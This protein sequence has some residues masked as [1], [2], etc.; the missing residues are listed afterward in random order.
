MSNS[1][2]RVVVI[3]LD[4]AD[5]RLLSP[6]IEQGS[7]PTLAQLVA[8]GRAGPL[9]STVRPES[10]VAWSS[11]ATGAN[12]G[13]HGIF[14]FVRAEPSS[15]R[16]VLANGDDIRARRFWEILGDYG[17]RVGL[18][19]VPF[20][21]PPRPVNGFLV[22]GM[23]TPGTHV[24]FTHPAALQSQILER[25]PDYCF[26]PS[27][28]LADRAALVTK[29]ARCT[30][31]QRDV[32]LW[33]LTEDDCDCL[34]VVFTGPDRLQHYVWPPAGSLQLDLLTDHYRMLDDAIAQILEKL[35][36]DT[37]LLV[38]SDHGFNSVGR[39]FFVNRW[40]YRQGL[41]ALRDT[42]QSRSLLAG[43]LS[44]LKQV[45]LLR[46]LKQSLLGPGW[47]P[48]Q[49]KRQQFSQS[50]DWAL[51]RAYFSPDGGLRIQPARSTTGGDEEPGE[52]YAQ[53][54]RQLQQGLT[55]LRDE[56][57]GLPVISSV[58]RRE[59][60]YSGP[61]VHEAPDLIV[62]PYR[63]HPE[64]EGNFILDGTLRDISGPLFEDAVPYVANHAPD[65]ILLAAGPGVG[66]G[67]LSARPHIIDLA[68][69]VLAALGVPIPAEMDGRVLSELLDPDVI[70]TIRY[71]DVSAGVSPSDPEH[72]FDQADEET[73]AERLRGLGY[74]D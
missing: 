31:Q 20:T 72:R 22:S 23:L 2:G 65:G 50:I 48:A 54:C 46:H 45:P 8:S 41:L 35:P 60:L 63:L 52:G 4:G 9:A 29:V 51:T 68:P 57:T 21:Y 14:G 25:F 28:I 42:A 74:L 17:R 19:N 1:T 44:R 70:A 62:E 10:S 69:T 37:L 55:E 73:I 7:L 56:Q 67:E 36:Q 15:H 34:V 18:I 32:T 13:R 11:F 24:P 61:F 5:W 12:P 38:M 33:L 30:E 39:R 53:L 66:P 26:D 64:P 49:L 43:I 6:L 27:E 71:S 16:F 3:G 40:L 47:G 58:P 59:E